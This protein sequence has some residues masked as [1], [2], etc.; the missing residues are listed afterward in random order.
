MGADEPGFDVAEQGMDDREE[1]AGLGALVLDHR[2]VPQVPAEIGVLT[3]IAGKA[4]GQELR[5]GRDICFEEG[6]KLGSGGGR[7]HSDAGVAGK[8]PVLT[9]DRMAML[10]LPVLRCRHLLDGGDDQALIGVLGAAAAAGRIAAAADEGFVGFQKAA[11]RTRRILA[12]SMAQLVRHRPCR[13][14]GHAQLALEKLRRD[15]ALVAAHK[16]GG[17]KPLR[18]SGARAMKHRPRRRRF[19]A[20]ASSTFIDPRPRLEPPSLATAAPGTDKPARPPQ[21]R[22]VLDAPLLRPKPRRKLQKPRHPTPHKRLALCYPAARSLTRT[23]S[24]PALPG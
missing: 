13:L 22:Q 4:V 12:Q 14:I 24:E 20:M 2:G 10:A 7:Q 18:E 3:A 9:L 1:L 11:Q 6:A 19:L 5:I 23:F 15:A 21:P 16:V 17:E 8:E